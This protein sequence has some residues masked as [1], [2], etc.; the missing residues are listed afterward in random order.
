M[1][2]Y[3]VKTWTC[4]SERKIDIW[5]SLFCFRSALSKGKIEVSCW[6]DWQNDDRHLGGAR[7]LG[8][9]ATTRDCRW[10]RIRRGK[11]E[12]ET[13]RTFTDQSIGWYGSSFRPLT[14]PPL[15]RFSFAFSCGSIHRIWNTSS[16][17][18]LISTQ[19]TQ[20]RERANS[21][22]QNRF[23]FVEDERFKLAS[24]SAFEVWEREWTVK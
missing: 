15:L 10:V 23:L 13:F 2:I 5:V 24:I 18:W 14:F 21:L 22:G 17:R 6:S 16:M 4:V 11:L 9:H 19:A 8:P 7:W 3:I 12:F 20:L 1:C